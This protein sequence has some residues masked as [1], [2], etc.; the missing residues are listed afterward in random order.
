M[1]FFFSSRRRHT[2]FD[3]DWSSD[4]CSSDLTNVA[5][6]AGATRID[7]AIRSDSN[8]LVLTVED[9]GRGID[10]EV[11]RSPKSLGLLGVRERVL[12]FSGRVDITGVPGG[13]PV[14]KRVVLGKREDFGG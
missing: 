14:R 4:V 7:V 1:D 13:G 2:R 11:A 3:C 8:E 6:H 9:N 12:P 10:A 5:R